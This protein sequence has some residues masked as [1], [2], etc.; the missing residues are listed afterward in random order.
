VIEANALST[1]DAIRSDALSSELLISLKHTLR[2][3]MITQEFN[4]FYVM[5]VL[6]RCCSGAWMASNPEPHYLRLRVGY[7][8]V[9][10]L[11]KNIKVVE[12]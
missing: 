9:R 12:H 1:A 7:E 4:C 8:G 5:S 10:P 6:Y 11:V 3:I 2:S